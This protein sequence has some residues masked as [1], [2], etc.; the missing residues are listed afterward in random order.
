MKLRDYIKALQAL[1]TKVGGDATVVQL[2]SHEGVWFPSSPPMEVTE[3][4]KGAALGLDLDLGVVYPAVATQT[5]LW[6]K[7]AN[8]GEG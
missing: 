3:D 1:E 5:P 6:V 8:K 4:T 7:T 2:D